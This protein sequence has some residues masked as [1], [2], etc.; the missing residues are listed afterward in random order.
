MDVLTYRQGSVYSPS[1]LGC[2]L[3]KNV[4]MST[5]DVPWKNVRSR[6]I[7]D[8]HSQ[9]AR[10]I[11]IYIVREQTKPSIGLAMVLIGHGITLNQS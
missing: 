3:K 4:K 8:L 10:N 2:G 11:L 5:F 6:D 1:F 9:P 7:Q